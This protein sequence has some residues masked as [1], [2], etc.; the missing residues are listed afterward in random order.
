[1]LRISVAVCSVVA[2]TSSESN[3]TVVMNEPAT[4]QIYT[5]SITDASPTLSSQPRT[6][7]VSRMLSS[8]RCN[9]SASVAEHK[10]EEATYVLPSHCA[11]H[12][13]TENSTIL[14]STP[15]IQ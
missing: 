3:V 7:R 4:T 2:G 5:K 1:M 12:R 11:F 9:T 15:D 8:A 13:Y 6:T 14:I 10:D